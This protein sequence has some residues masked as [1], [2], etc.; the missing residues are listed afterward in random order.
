MRWDDPTT[1]GDTERE[2]SKT[3]LFKDCSLS[4]VKKPVEQLVFV[5]LLM[6]KYKIT[7]IM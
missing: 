7:G 4:S 3:L 2:N 6:S 5:T 1:L